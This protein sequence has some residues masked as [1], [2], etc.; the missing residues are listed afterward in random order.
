MRDLTELN[1]KDKAVMMEAT[2]LSVN[3]M[4]PGE[5]YMD[6]A[7][8]TRQYHAIMNRIIKAWS[9]AYVIPSDDPS[10]DE[11]GNKTYE[12]SLLVLP[13]DDYNELEDAVQPYVDKLNGGGPKGRK[14]TTSSSN[15]TSRAGV[16]SSRRA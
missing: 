12:A 16:R 8:M 6:L 9:F 1:A 14:T 10:E 7:G 3:W 11:D 13:I 4:R 5:S 2:R 15:G